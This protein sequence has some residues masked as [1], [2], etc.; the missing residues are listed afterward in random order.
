[1]KKLKYL[2]IFIFIVLF[3]GVCAADVDLTSYLENPSF[4][5]PILF[6]LEAVCD[7]EG[8]NNFYG[9]N[10]VYCPTVVYPVGTTSDPC[11]PFYASEGN[12]CL[13]QIGTTISQ[14]PAVLKIQSNTVY[15]MQADILVTSA[16]ANSQDA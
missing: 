14:V 8:W 6:P 7:A 12:N 4:E 16:E 1:M 10:G 2:S 15:T 9:Y 5:T 13:Q 3:C 11:L